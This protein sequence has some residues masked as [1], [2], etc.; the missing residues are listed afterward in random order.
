MS[1]TITET[2]RQIIKERAAAGEKDAI[3]VKEALDKLLPVETK[4]V[5]KAPAPEEPSKETVR[6]EE[7]N[8]EQEPKTDTEEKVDQEPKAPEADA[9]EKMHPATRRIVEREVKRSLARQEEQYRR[10]IDEM[11]ELFKS[12]QPKTPEPPAPSEDDILTDLLSKP[13]EF[14][15]KREKPLIDRIEQMINKNLKILPSILR[16]QA[17]G[18]QALKILQS[19]KGFDHESDEGGARLMAF[20]SKK[21]KIPQDVLVEMFRGRVLDFANLAKEHW[22]E[23]KKLSDVSL[24]DKKA[25]SSGASPNGHMGSSTMSIEKLSKMYAVAKTP[26]EAKKIEEQMR[27]LAK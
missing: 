16:Q 4:S 17:E 20:L 6:P 13:S 19:L 9:R 27:A 7:L 3:Q 12:S 11:K 2:E 5:E 23:D 22:E 1:T 8:P 10:T 18:D 25:A 24:V 15:T 14:L 26:E 21:T